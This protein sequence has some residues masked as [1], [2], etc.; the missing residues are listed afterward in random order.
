M[1][2]SLR[3]IIY[4]VLFFI[5][6]VISMPFIL[7][8]GPAKNY[9][10]IPYL[11]HSF[12]GK[13][14]VD[15]VR[16][17]WF[18]PQR[19]KHFH[20]TGKDESHV[21]FDTLAIYS[22]IY[23]LLFTNEWIDKVETENLSASLPHLAA[24]SFKET[25]TPLSLTISEITGPVINLSVTQEHEIIHIDASSE[26]GHADIYISMTKNGPVFSK[27]GKIVYSMPHDL[28]QKLKEHDFI[29][30]DSPLEISLLTGKG[31]QFQ[32]HPARMDL[33]NGI[34]LTNVEGIVLLSDSLKKLDLDL[35]GIITDKG[36]DSDAAVRGWVSLSE[37]RNYDLLIEGKRLRASLLNYLSPDKRLKTW[38]KSIFGSNIDGSLRLVHENKEQYGLLKLT[39]NTAKIPGAV[40]EWD[41]THIS[42][43]EPVNITIDY[44]PHAGFSDS[45]P[46]TLPLTIQVNRL[47]IHLSDSITPKDIA[48]ESTI[49][50]RDLEFSHLPWVNQCHFTNGLLTLN[51]LSLEHIELSLIGRLNRFDQEK[52]L[53]RSLGDELRFNLSSELK[54]SKDFIP[55]VQKFEVGAED[56]QLV[57][58]LTGKE[59]AENPFELSSSGYINYMLTPQ[60]LSRIQDQKQHD[61]HL[62]SPSILQ[63]LL[64]EAKFDIRDFSL[65]EISSKGRLLIDE[66]AV[67]EDKGAS[68]ASLRKIFIP[69]SANAKDDVLTFT[70]AAVT[71][72]RSLEQK[73]K[74]EGHVRVSGWTR[75][76]EDWKVNAETA[77]TAFPVAIISAFTG[78]DELD[79]L[80]GPSLDAAVKVYDDVDGSEGH[81]IFSANGDQFDIAGSL[82]ADQQLT[83]EDPNRPVV[84]HWEM[85]PDR[86]SAIR[87]QLLCQDTVLIDQ[88]QL[89]QSTS[90]QADISNLVI[91]LKKPSRSSV[92]IELNTAGIYVLD[93]ITNDMVFFD[94]VSARATSKDIS[95]SIGIQFDAGGNIYNEQNEELRL[96]LNSVV[97]DIFHAD[98]SFN[99]HGATIEVQAEA[100]QAPVLLLSN[101]LCLD[102]SVLNQVNALIGH[103]VNAQ[104]NVNLSEMTGPIQLAINGTIGKLSLDGYL[105]QGILTLQSPLSAEFSITPTLQDSILDELLPFLNSAYSSEEPIRITINQNGFSYPLWSQDPYQFSVGAMRIDLGK[106][107]FKNDYQI[108]QI[109]NILKYSTDMNLISVWF[110]PLY[111]SYES[112]VANIDRIDMLVADRYPVAV[113]GKVNFYDDYINMKIGLGGLTL[114]QAFGLKGVPK[115]YY[116]QLSMKGSLSDPSINSN[117]ASTK[118]A[119]FIAQLRGGPQ[120]VIVG[121]LMD[122]LGGT[123]GQKPIPKP[124]TQPFPWEIQPHN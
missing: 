51:A 13:V 65:S 94:G 102:E 98:G 63:L 6:F 107:Y 99:R 56:G 5:G 50:V 10:L 90:I 7:S 38:A 3:I 115:D 44:T 52:P 77:I 21:K 92:A 78:I 113:W 68:I 29:T 15:R 30:F 57:F 25:F 101:F 24:K 32:L 34:S 33:Q 100:H 22:P 121:G 59:N 97:K 2:K 60:L 28:V 93:M 11:E 8:T 31:F 80:I 27:E 76:I 91:P 49:S 70:I 106:M 117:K 45:L 14:H 111:L 35:S 112:G 82:K 48:L 4:A 95:D 23:R 105:S 42:L 17:S 96:S 64:D 66:I 62:S 26:N 72:N 124:T 69:W 20:W 104:L 36:G 43:A 55:H 116:L 16:L 103:R 54:L 46:K 120:G 110:T 79:G 41:D 81:V 19:A 87:K 122:L 73:G 37:N 18:G 71:A 53:S 12:G 108:A 89:H 58:N 74:L 86:F 1:A 85:T 88:L 40:F 67:G 119:A 47:N 9:L 39:S 118:I 123:L 83:L 75:N 84:I 114:R 61:Y 109:L